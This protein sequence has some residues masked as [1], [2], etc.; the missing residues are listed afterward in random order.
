MVSPSV[1]SQSGYSPLLLAQPPIPVSPT[2]SLKGG[3]GR[4][5]LGGGSRRKRES[6]STSPSR[7]FLL[8]QARQIG[9]SPSAYLPPVILLSLPCK[10]SR[11][12]S[13][14]SSIM[15]F[16]QNTLHPAEGRHRVTKGFQHRGDYIWAKW[17]LL[18]M[19][20]I[21]IEMDFLEFVAG[22]SSLD[23][24]K[25]RINTPM[26]KARWGRRGQR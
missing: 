5:G 10:K 24:L 13:S 25:K 12:S 3:S 4:E 11:R 9:V 2:A 14:I 17:L 7:T 23:T 18:A 6:Y 26:S 20:E 16:W 21:D 8:L 19:R 15:A 22:S 1:S